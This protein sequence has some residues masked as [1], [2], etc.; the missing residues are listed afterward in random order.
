MNSKL[1]KYFC[2]IALGL[3]SLPLSA[4]PT[5]VSARLD[6]NAIEMG[7]KTVLHVQVVG[8]RG[9][10]G[11][12]PLLRESMSNGFAT[13]L[14][15]TIEL[16]TD[17]KKSSVDLGSGR[18]QTS[19]EIPVQAFDSGFYTLPPL[20]Y[21]TG[22]DTVLSNTVQLKVFPVEEKLTASSPISDYTAPAAPVQPGTWASVK[23][24]LIIYWWI[25]A[26]V[27]LAAAVALAGIRWWKHRRKN[28]IRRKALQPPYPEAMQQL[29]A[30]KAKGLWEKGLEKEYFTELIDILRRY[31]ARRFEIPAMEMNS[32]QIR[33]EVKRHPRLAPFREQFSAVLTVADMAKFANMTLTPDEN[34]GAFREVQEF[35]ERTKPT[36]Q[37][38][39]EDKERE[40][41]SLTS[42]RRK[43]KV[44]DKQARK[45]GKKAFKGPSSSKGASAQRG[46]GSQKG[47]KPA[48]KGKKG[49][50]K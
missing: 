25:P 16:G 37:E 45:P 21:V 9:K 15:D 17:F 8:D 28:P 24:W 30:L 42:P 13:L 34:T 12:F 44:S 6:V 11:Y 43:G 27:V 22:T 49:G 26:A 40:E 7:A 48:A 23:E 31:I 29:A 3:T 39:R 50:R 18:I 19:Y 41:A 14:G 2:T 32:D 1:L 10:E 46:S 38:E 36:V 4:G 35:V 5:Q 33:A 47:R 20:V